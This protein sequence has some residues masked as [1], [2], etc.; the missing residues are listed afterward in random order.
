MNL[1][2]NLWPFF[3]TGQTVIFK[4]TKEFITI[5]LFS[6]FSSVKEMLHL[7]DIN[8]WRNLKSRGKQIVTS[9]NNEYSNIGTGTYVKYFVIFHCFFHV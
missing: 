9:V 3:F 1:I 2:W 7:W 8:L 5:L 4:I 6:K